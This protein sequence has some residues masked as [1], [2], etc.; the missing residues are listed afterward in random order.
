MDNSTQALDDVV[1]EFWSLESI[2]IQPV[3]E[4]KSTCNSELLTNFHQSFEI[5]DGRQVAKLPWKSKVQ[6]SSN[7]YEVAIPRFNSLPRKLHT[8][9][10]FKQGYSEIMQDYIDKK[11]S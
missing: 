11:T 3:Q 10:V 8:D 7:N 4:K 2:G 6:L 1:R 9:T 5:I